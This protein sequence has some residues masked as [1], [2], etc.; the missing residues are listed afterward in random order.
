MKERKPYEDDDGRT[1]AKMDVDGMPWYLERAR[2][3]QDP[4]KQPIELSKAERWA[5]LKGVLAA[6]P[7]SS[8]SP[9][10]SGSSNNGTVQKGPA[11]YAGGPFCCHGRPASCAE[12]VKNGF[13]L[14]I[15]K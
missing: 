9:S 7:C 6:S 11:A 10:I 8:S 3:N 14:T 1:I 13:F 2:R 12:P 5:M 4:D 15:L